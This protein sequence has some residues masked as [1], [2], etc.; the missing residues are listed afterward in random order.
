MRNS[1]KKKTLIKKHTQ[2][3]KKSALNPFSCLLNVKRYLKEKKNSLKT[4]LK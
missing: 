3:L 4:K 2:N 1:Q